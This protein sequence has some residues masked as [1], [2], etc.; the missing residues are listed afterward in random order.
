MASCIFT[1]NFTSLAINLLLLGSLTFRPHFYIRHLLSVTLSTKP[2]LYSLRC[3]FNNLITVNATRG[4]LLGWHQLLPWLWSL[5]VTSVTRHTVWV[6][7]T[8][9]SS[10]NHA[11]SSPSHHFLGSLGWGGRCPWW[12]EWRVSKVPWR[13]CVWC[14]LYPESIQMLRIRAGEAWSWFIDDHRSVPLPNDH[15]NNLMP[16]S[17]TKPHRALHR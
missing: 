11:D 17:G 4:T 15:R 6:P 12:V 10:G 16:P 5:A 8:G 14:S 3:L 13:A 9:P 2:G 7:S 1:C